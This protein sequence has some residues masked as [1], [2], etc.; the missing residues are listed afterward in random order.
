MHTKFFFIFALV[1]LSLS[2]SSNGFCSSGLLAVNSSFEE[3][4]ESEI[5]NAFKPVDRLTDYLLS[6]EYTDTDHFPEEFNQQLELLSQDQVF[7]SQNVKSNG[8]LKAS[9]FLMGCAFGPVGVI[10]VYIASG[11]N[12]PEFYS[13]LA[14]CILSNLTFWVVF[15]LSGGEL[16]INIF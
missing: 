15:F 2:F 10:V 1:S 11:N 3:Y 4:D 12:R 5:Y 8:Y 7:G 14:G 13:S 16:S 6:D 9:A